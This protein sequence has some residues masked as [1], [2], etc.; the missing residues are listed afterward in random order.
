MKYYVGVDGG[1]SKTD[2]IVLQE[3]CRK[4]LHTQ[5]GSASWREFGTEA[6]MQNI[7]EAITELVPDIQEKIAA[8]VLGMPCHGESKQGDRQLNKEL[9]NAFPETVYYLTNDVEV[10]WAGSLAIQPG[11]NVVAGTGSIAYGK[12]AYGNTARAGGWDEFY[13][14]EGSGYWIGRRMME[15]F[16]KQSDGRLPRGPLY[17]IVRNELN[18]KDDMEFIDVIRMN[19]LTRR[20]SVARLQILMEQA[21]LAGDQTAAEV[22]NHAGAEL[23]MQAAA[24]KNKL[25][26]GREGCDISCSGGLIRTGNLILKP[27]SEILESQG[28]RVIRPK[29]SPVEG[30]VLLA[31]EKFCPEGLDTYKK[32]LGISG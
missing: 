4:F 28:N 24:V 20:E 27:F 2:I 18:I 1:G 10:G 11:I 29:C 30:A 7:K 5:T 23:A 13:S 16:S 15:V 25:Q 3:N 31:L 12:D 9:K 26:F 17:D 6:V 8:M 19:Y 21:A 14:D 32:T 22:Y